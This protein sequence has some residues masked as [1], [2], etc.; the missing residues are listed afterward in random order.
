MGTVDE[1]IILN[2]QAEMTAA[3]LTTAVLN[4]QATAQSHDIRLEDVPAQ[5]QA[6][7]VANSTAMERRLRDI[8]A[9]VDRD[10]EL[11]YSHGVAL[12]RIERE[13]QRRQPKPKG[14]VFTVVTRE[15]DGDADIGP[16][17][18]SRK[19]A[20]AYAKRWPGNDAV[21]IEVRRIDAEEPGETIAVR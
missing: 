14:T 4:L 3:Q 21:W 6:A 2:P 1:P 17:F 16:T 8:E 15:P 11:L 19:R 9:Q 5:V 13:L 10:Q 20:K 18:S 7:V 12:T